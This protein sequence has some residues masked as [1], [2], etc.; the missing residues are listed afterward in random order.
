MKWFGNE[1]LKKADRAAFG[2]VDHTAGFLLVV[3][4]VRK[5]I[6]ASITIGG[7]QRLCSVIKIQQFIQNR[8]TTIAAV[9]QHLKIFN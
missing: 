1:R 8:L 4:A 9:H 3:K 7:Y 6:P 2:T 5:L